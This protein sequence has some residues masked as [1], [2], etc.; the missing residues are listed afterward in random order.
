MPELTIEE[1]QSN[2]TGLHRRISALENELAA[3]KGRAAELETSLA[4][5]AEAEQT[6]TARIDALDS[7]TAEKVRKIELNAHLRTRCAEAN[8]DPMLLDGIAFT[9]EKDVERRVLLLLKNREQIERLAVNDLIAT[10]SHRPG[11]GTGAEL[12]DPLEAGMG[13]EERGEYRRMK[14]IF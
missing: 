5:A 14:R 7:A 10:Q 11:S 4:S 12:G 6:L 8:V 3:A 1:L 2:N 9:D 13:P